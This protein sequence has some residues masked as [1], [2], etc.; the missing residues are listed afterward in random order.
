M[1]VGNS[2]D[3]LNQHYSYLH[4]HQHYIHKNMHLSEIQFGQSVIDSP[5]SEQTTPT[6]P[7]IVGQTSIRPIPPKSSSA[8]KIGPRP[9]L[10]PPYVTASTV[11]VVK[12]PPLQPKSSLRDF[13][14]PKPAAA[15]AASSS[16]SAAT[17]PTVKASAAEIFSTGYKRSAPVTLSSSQVRWRLSLPKKIAA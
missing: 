10:P 16:S 13:R 8:S 15:A 12:P 7:I 3:K 1:L 9:P 11:P 6:Q 5:S 4:L 2:K 17:A 14:K